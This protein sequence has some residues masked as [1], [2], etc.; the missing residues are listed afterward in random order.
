MGADWYQK[1]SGEV[2]GE[3]GSS[4]DGLSAREA[5]NRLNKY[6]P[7]EL[8]EKKKKTAFMM[9]MDQFTDFM[10]IVLMAA[11]VVAGMAGKPTAAVAILIICAIVFAKGLLRGESV[12][13]MFL[14]ASALRLPLY[15]RP[16]PR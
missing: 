16:C 3:L 1:E 12:M 6:G 5:Q 10:I 13:L 11:V 15:P 7:N 2:V 9:L 8:E 14:T 4:A